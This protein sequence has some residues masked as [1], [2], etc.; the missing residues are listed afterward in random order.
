MDS[1]GVQD[2]AVRSRGPHKDAD[3]TR[4]FLVDGCGINM[5]RCLDIRCAPHGAVDRRV[6]WTSH[7]SLRSARNVRF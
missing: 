5:G 4:S 1:R 7:I 3:A 2:P 6:Q